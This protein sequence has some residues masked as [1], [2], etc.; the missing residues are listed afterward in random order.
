MPLNKETK[1]SQT[2]KLIHEITDLITIYYFDARIE[3]IGDHW[4]IIL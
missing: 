1:P 3:F 4:L 2:K